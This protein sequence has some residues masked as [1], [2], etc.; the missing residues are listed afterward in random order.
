MSDSGSDE[1]LVPLEVSQQSKLWVLCH[2]N[3]KECQGEQR[4]QTQRALANPKEVGSQELDPA[5][6]FP[7]FE[8]QYRIEDNGIWK[9]TRASDCVG[10]EQRQRVFVPFREAEKQAC[11]EYDNMF[12]THLIQN[13]MWKLWSTTE[14]IIY[15]RQTFH[16]DASEDEEEEEEK[17]K[18]LR[19]KEEPK[20]KEE[21]RVKEEAE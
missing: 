16:I 10:F 11:I 15:N 3:R 5:R 12:A 1:T 9:I 4:E 20:V 2:Q 21:P 6:R 14:S 13:R 17:N 8:V 7:D 19:V 18:E